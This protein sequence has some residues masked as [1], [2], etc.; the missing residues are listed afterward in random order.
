MVVAIVGITEYMTVSILYRRRR[1]QAVN[2]LWNLCRT[3][4]VR[5]P[6]KLG[7]DQRKTWPKHV[8]D[9]SRHFIFRCRKH[10]KFQ[11]FSETL[12]GRLPLEDSS[13]RLETWPKCVSD[14]PRH[15]I[16]RPPKLFFRW[17]FLSKNVF[18]WLK[19][20]SATFWIIEANVQ[21]YMRFWF[22]FDQILGRLSKFLKKWLLD[23]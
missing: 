5:L 4:N 10:Q 15:F 7:S 21:R 1:H 11:F 9:D 12:N 22:R 2:F 16:F 14:D 8:L 17:T 6:L 20:T 13:D 3:L 19:K 23:F 18:F